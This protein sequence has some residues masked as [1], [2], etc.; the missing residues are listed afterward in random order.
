MPINTPFYPRQFTI[1]NHEGEAQNLLIFLN[2]KT[3]RVKLRGYIIHGGCWEKFAKW[4]GLR[5]RGVAGM[6]VLFV[7]TG[8]SARS[9]MA[10]AFARHL[11][12]G[13]VEAVSAGIDPKGLHPLT[14]KVMAE[15]GIDVAH[16]SSKVLTDEMIHEAEY[17]IT[18][19]GH[20]DHNC[21]VLPAR[22][23]RLHWAI[24]DPAVVGEFESD[25]ALTAF[26]QARDDL[27]WRVH[28]FVSTL[29][30]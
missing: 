8:N 1:G 9:Q 6:K 21:P 28:E 24:E 3:W 30:G 12:A 11:G 16:Q 4:V 14:V 5:V 15:R 25:E 23:K 13:K 29:P 10:E 7:C 18:V 2:I 26:R 22:A 19:C 20:A 27:E 17:V